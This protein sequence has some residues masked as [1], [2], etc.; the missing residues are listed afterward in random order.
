MTHQ[1]RLLRKLDRADL[2][3]MSAAEGAQFCVGLERDVPRRVRL[4]L[5]ALVARGRH[6]RQVRRNGI[7]PHALGD[8]AAGA[9]VEG[10]EHG[11]G[12]RFAGPSGHWPGAKW[13]FFLLAA[14]GPLGDG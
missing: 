14:L 8:E 6:V 5:A 3:T 7:E 4:R 12:L 1:W 13:L 9:D 10:A 11:V 2:H